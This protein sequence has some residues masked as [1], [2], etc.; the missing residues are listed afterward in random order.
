VSGFSTVVVTLDGSGNGVAHVAPALYFG[1]SENAI[2]VTND[3][4][5][6]DVEESTQGNARFVVG[7]IAVTGP[8][9]AEVALYLKHG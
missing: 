3:G 9:N 4:D 8:A 7:D 5:S 6:L 2:T 1:A